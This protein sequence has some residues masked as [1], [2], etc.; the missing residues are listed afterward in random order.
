MAF[1]RILTIP[2]LGEVSAHINDGYEGLARISWMNDQGEPV[3][4]FLPAAI[5]M[6]WPAQLLE[7]FGELKLSITYA[8]GRVRLRPHKTA[9]GLDPGAYIQIP[10]RMGIVLDFLRVLEDL[11]GIP[12][13]RS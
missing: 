8:A 4:Q 12:A 9:P 5:L 10:I 1:M 13:R 2:G 6:S 7:V 3:E 11:E